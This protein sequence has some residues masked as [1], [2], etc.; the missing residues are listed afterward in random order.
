MSA[1]INEKR[2]FSTEEI[3]PRVDSFVQLNGSLDLYT[4][5][6]AV[7]WFLSPDRGVHAG[8]HAVLAPPGAFLSRNHGYG[9]EGGL[10]RFFVHLPKYSTTIRSLA[11]Y[12]SL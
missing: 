12:G 11:P 5:F 8:M 4:G 6:R 10:G 1:L 7:D 2:W 3:A 9:I